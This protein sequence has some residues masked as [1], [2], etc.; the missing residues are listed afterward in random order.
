MATLSDVITFGSPVLLTTTSPEGP[1]TRPVI[2]QPDPEPGSSP[3]AVLTMAA[4]AKVADIRRDAQV[5]L[6]GTTADGFFALIAEA[7]IVEDPQLV[8]RGMAHFL[9]K[10]GEDSAPHEDRGDAAPPAVLIR[11]RPLSGKVW[12]VHS[13]APFDNEVADLEL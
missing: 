11:L 1:R 5:S 6:S 9:G 8:E 13:P 3:I 4:A 7:E 2:A 10:N 12:T